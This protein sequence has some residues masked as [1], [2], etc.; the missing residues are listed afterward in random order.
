MSNF[1]F[2]NVESVLKQIAADR[3]F[4]NHISI[5]LNLFED[6][7]SLP[8]G[9]GARVLPFVNNPRIPHVLE[10]GPTSFTNDLSLAHVIESY[11]VHQCA[12]SGARASSLCSCLATSTY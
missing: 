9:Q 7:R 10:S 11:I 1:Q 12:Q 2:G 3:S 6:A 4:V 8:K 5:L